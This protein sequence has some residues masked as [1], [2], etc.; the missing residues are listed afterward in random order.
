MKEKLII[1][2]FGPIKSVDLD[3]GKITVLIGDQATGKSTVAKVLSICRYFS[4]I[5]DYNPLERGSIG[6]LEGAFYKGL[7][8]WGIGSYKKKDTYIYYENSDYSVEVTTKLE[9][10]NV[11]L[12]DNENHIK[13][14]LPLLY[15]EL[16]EKSDRF[17]KL[18]GELEEIKPKFDKPL[19]VI[20][21]SWMPSENFF[22]LNVKKV[23]D[24]PYYLSEKRGLQS[25]FS[26]GKSPDYSDSLHWQLASLYNIS[27]KFK[28]E[29]SIKPLNIKYKNINGVAYFKGEKDED[30]Y[31]LSQ[32]ASG[33]QATIPI[34]LAVKYYSEFEKRKRTFI[35]EEPEINLFPTVQRKLMTFFVENINVNK[36]SFLIPT[37][38]PYF[39]SAINDLL[40]AYKR[41]QINE[42][43]TN[44]I[45]N[46]ETWL[47]PDD[48]SVYE[49]KK[50]KASSIFDKKLGLIS[51]NILNKKSH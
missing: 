13:K 1:K 49:L 51:D 30:Y 6:R 2:N 21:P 7:V 27:D 31:K 11:D 8:E 18:L 20:D 26:L 40:I 47:N 23:M 28:S 34:V 3:L 43:E 10:V 33:Y 48:L 35:I 38:S 24:N 46:K 22:R 36:H 5:V 15:C 14:E 45:I 37:H 9:F 32:G 50:G 12:D 16:N 25:I 17:K 39:L 41:G 44:K 19:K 42:V 29:T 4:Y